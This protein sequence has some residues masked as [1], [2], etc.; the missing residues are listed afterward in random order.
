[1]AHAAFTSSHL[2]LGGV[3]LHYL[4]WGGAGPPFVMLHGLTGNARNWDPVAATLSDQYR[5]LALDQRGHGDSSWADEYGT[6][7]MTRDLRHFLDALDL[8]EIDLMGLS[9]G[10]LVAFQ[11]AAANPERVRRLIV[12]DIG[13]EYAR[14]AARQVRATLAANDIFNSADEAA[15]QL[16]AINTRASDEAIRHRVV[17]NLRP[18]PDG[19]LTFKYD[20]KLRDLG[21][22]RDR[23]GDELWA[24]WRT[25]SCP[26]LLVRGDE[27]DVLTAEAAQRMLAEN[28]HASLVT[29]AESGHSVT[30]DNPQGLLAALGPWLAATAGPAPLA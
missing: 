12:L 14:T 23:S 5:V 17:H 19:T 1:V 11:F 30:L 29:V 10:G 22:I 6:G 4:D 28:P 20:R 13:P 3:T 26:V 9:M 27:S 8:A 18:L 16:R 25:V 21:A 15:A 24:A 7:A 2:S